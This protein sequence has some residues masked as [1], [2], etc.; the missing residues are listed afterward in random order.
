MKLCKGVSL[1]MI[2]ICKNRSSFF[3][4]HLIC[5]SLCLQTFMIIQKTKLLQPVQNLFHHNQAIVSLFLHPSK[6]PEN[7]KELFLTIPNGIPGSCIAL[8]YW[9]SVMDTPEW[10][11]S[12]QCYH[13]IAIQR[14]FFLHITTNRKSNHD[15]DVFWSYALK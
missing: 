7:I 2:N 1:L 9:N 15:F 4:E 10:S 11:T 6:L 13:R 3:A 14:F 8:T 5:L 12:F